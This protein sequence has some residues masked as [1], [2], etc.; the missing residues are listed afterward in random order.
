MANAWR[1]NIHQRAKSDSPDVPQF[2]LSRTCEGWAVGFQ[3]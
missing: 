2:L 1:G 3:A